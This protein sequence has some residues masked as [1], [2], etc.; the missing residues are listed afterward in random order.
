MADLVKGELRSDEQTGLAR[1]GLMLTFARGAR[2]D[3]VALAAAL[4]DLPRTAI[5]HDPATAAMP[6]HSTRPSLAPR[7]D[8]QWLELVVDGLTFDLVGIAPGA[9]LA[10]PEVAYR[11]NCDVE[12]A[13]DSE[14]IGLFPG[15]HIAS[16]LRS[17]PILRTL[18]A[19]G[20]DLAER[21]DGVATVCWTPA[22]SAIAPQFFLRTVRAWLGGGAFPALGLLGLW[23][24]RSGALRSEGLSLLLGRELLID[25]ALTHDRARA[26]RL[27]IRAV[28]ELVGMRLPAARHDFT[29]EEGDCLVCEIDPATR[30]IDIRPG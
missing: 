18:L 29:T 9:A 10:P 8:A 6:L 19:L 25:P 12:G 30:V 22:R 2:P 11:F 21:L 23:F 26:M 7:G 14:A 20:A 28:H 5:S 16:G 15:P 3:R 17:L 24:D 27:A 1:P 13:G 4:A